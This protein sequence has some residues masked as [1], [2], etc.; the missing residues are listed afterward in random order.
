MYINLLHAT[1]SCVHILAHS[2]KSILHD[3]SQ[4]TSPVEPTS[5]CRYISFTYNYSYTY[6]Y[7]DNISYDFSEITNNYCTSY[8]K[9]DTP[10]HVDDFADLHNAGELQREDI[11]LGGC[12]HNNSSKQGCSYYKGLYNIVV[13]THTQNYTGTRYSVVSVPLISN[14][15]QPST[16]TQTYRPDRKSSHVRVNWK[17]IADDH[18]T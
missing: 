8:E 11:S 5:L 14:R 7:V 15:T 2:S 4:D 13:Y 17:L 18:K 12:C 10:Q 6:T 1:D 3:H 16:T 9:W